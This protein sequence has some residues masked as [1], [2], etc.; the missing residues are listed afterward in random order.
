MK[1]DVDEL[2]RRL[3]QCPAPGTLWRHF[4]GNLYRVVGSAID[5]ATLEPLVLYRPEGSGLTWARPLRV[6]GE[7]VRGD[8]GDVPR[9]SPV[10]G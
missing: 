2:S 6:W 4:K 7:V 3:A 8:A 5:E 1:T 9:F 10:D